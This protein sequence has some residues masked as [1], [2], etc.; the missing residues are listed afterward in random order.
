MESPSILDLMSIPDNERD[1]TW[2]TRFLSILP[3]SNLRLIYPNPQQG[4]DGFPYLYAEAT[5]AA[6]EPA[7]QIFDWLST[8]GIGLLINPHKEVPDYILTFGM[9]WNF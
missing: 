7:I 2:E 5:A 9:I 8:R 4:M 3:H 1:Q 6:T